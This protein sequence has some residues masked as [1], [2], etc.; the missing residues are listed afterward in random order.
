M[1][2]FVEAVVSKEKSHLIPDNDDC[3]GR[4]IGTLRQKR[5]RMD[6]ALCAEEAR[7]LV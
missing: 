7:Q 4:W 2:N 1:G 5:N 6:G 3:W